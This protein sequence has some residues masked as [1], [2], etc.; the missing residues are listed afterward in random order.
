M[1]HAVLDFFALPCGFRFKRLSLS[2]KKAPLLRIALSPR[3][4][5]NSN[6]SESLVRYND[7]LASFLRCDGAA[8]GARS[9]VC[10]VNPRLDARSRGSEL[11]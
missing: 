4:R 7:V 10:T 5:R 1:A 11:R 9:R 2:I 8:G 6:Q 3:N